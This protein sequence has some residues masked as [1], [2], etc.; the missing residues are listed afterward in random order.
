[1]IQYLLFIILLWLHMFLSLFFLSRWIKYVISIILL[2]LHHL[3]FQEHSVLLLVKNGANVISNEIKPT[4]TL[5]V[6][7]NKPDAAFKTSLTD[8]WIDHLVCLICYWPLYKWVKG[9]KTIIY[10]CFLWFYG[11]VHSAL[12]WILFT[13]Y[14]C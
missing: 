6:D 2:C 12:L 1:M 10:F 3:T 5:N 9:L 8:L 4:K 13:V 14:L 7:F 11:W